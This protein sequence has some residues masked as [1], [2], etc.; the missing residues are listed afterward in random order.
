MDY[1]VLKIDELQIQL[2]KNA[3][4]GD[5]ASFGKLCEMFYGSMTAIAYNVLGDHHLAE[6]AVQEGFA[7]ALVK[8]PGLKKPASYG[9]WLGRICRNAAIDAARARKQFTGSEQLEFLPAK[10]EHNN[11]VNQAV[12]LA[13]KDL[14]DDSRELIVMRYYNKMSH[15]QMAA[16]LGQTKGSINS[17]LQ[18]IREKLAKILGKQALLEGQL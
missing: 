11:E 9:G 5:L 8:L 17:K 7:K 3:I 6:D 1:G 10:K 12:R 2:V 4:T 15:L 14:P 18:R 16:A 13:I